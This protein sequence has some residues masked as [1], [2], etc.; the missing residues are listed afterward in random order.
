[1]EE[2]VLVSFQADSGASV[3]AWERGKR[4]Y[5]CADDW[6]ASER[7]WQPAVLVE[8][9][10]REL[11]R[12]VDL[13]VATSR[14]LGEKLRRMGGR[15]EVIPNGVDPA[16]FRPGGGRRPEG[17]AVVPPPPVVGFA[18]IMNR[19][20]FDAGLVEGM[21]R[22][23]GDWSFLLVGRVEGRGVDLSGLAGLPN[24]SLAG[25]QPRECLPWWV[26]RMDVCLIP[27]PASKWVERAFSLKL[28]EYLAMGKPVVASRTREYEPYEDVV[29]LAKG[30]VEFERAVEA[31]LRED[32]EE[33]KARRIALA[34]ENSWER[35]VDRFLEVLGRRRGGA[36][37]GAPGAGR[38]GP[39][40]FR[41]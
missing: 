13:V 39:E 33:M 29:R 31:A 7:W 8:A 11:V 22:R 4:V 25:F 17:G 21:A 10:E 18:G 23:H 37:G 35:R 32:S 3:S 28:F 19:Y 20:N 1:M 9:R 15:V 6:A 34:G 16:L 5:W 2:A 27:W 26:E 36:R 12:G 38:G 14:G 41:S 30:E 40:T 24:V